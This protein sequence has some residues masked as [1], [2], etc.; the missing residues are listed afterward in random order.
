VIC[1]SWTREVRPAGTITAISHADANGSPPAPVNA[2]VWQPVSRAF[3]T[4]LKM[5]GDFP[6]VLIATRTSPDCASPITCRA[7]TSANPKSL[8]NAVS[9]DVSVVNAIAGK[10]RRGFS[11]LP[12]SS[13]AMCWASAALPPFPH[14]NIFR[15]ACRASQISLPDRSISGSVVS[16]NDSNVW[17]CS[18]IEV[19]SRMVVFDV[20]L[21]IQYS[22]WPLWAC[23]LA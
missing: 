2:I 5:F 4:A 23:T 13:A 11:Y 22:V 12:I 21:K 20:S 17:R 19:V 3:S 10:D 16:T 8:L 1:A 9:D 15:P 14:S 7:N 6:L 18:R